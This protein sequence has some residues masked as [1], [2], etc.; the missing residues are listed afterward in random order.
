MAFPGMAGVP[1]NAMVNPVFPGAM[2]LPGFNPGM[3]M[4]PGIIP[5]MQGGIGPMRNHGRGM[6][7]GGGNRMHP[8]GQY[9]QKRRAPS[10]GGGGRPGG[11]PSFPGVVGGFGDGAF[12]PG[13]IDA[14]QGRSLKN[15]EDLDAAGDKGTGEL[16]Y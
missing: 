10:F 5:G 1:P 4:M 3:N 9:D 2:G 16:D 11:V 12:G 8:Y 14:S 6:P 7:N 13:P 15:Y